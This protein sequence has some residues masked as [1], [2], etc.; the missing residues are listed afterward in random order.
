MQQAI[1]IAGPTASGKSAFAIRLAKDFNGTVINAD[2]M[3]VY[4]D[5]RVLSARPSKAE[6]A[7][8]PHALYG[9][10]DGAEVCSAAMW[11]EMAMVEVRKCWDEG[12]IPI[13][14]GGTG[15]Y[16]RF[17]VEG[18]AAIPEIPEDIRQAVRRRIDE[19]GS[20]ALHAE[21]TLRDP[22][23]AKRLAPGDSQRIARAVEVLDTTGKSITQWQRV[24]EPGPLT[25]LDKEGGVTKFVL[26]TERSHLYDRCNLR[27]DLMLEQGAMDEAEAL[28]ER[29]LDPKLPLMKALG[30]PSLARYLAGELSLDEAIDEGK[31]QT[32]RFAKRQMTWFRNQF[33]HWI[34]VNTQQMETKYTEYKNIITHK[35]LD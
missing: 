35:C 13:L 19:E 14:V 24:N 26:E 27:F 25:A 11:T 2:S 29:S 17:L 16:F 22:E 1:L 34:S 20:E 6:E 31:M 10:L 8:V 18:M 4:S 32:R 5:L 21:L 7:E 23:T 28:K 15:M 12:R 33:A 3:Q 9:V 30:Y